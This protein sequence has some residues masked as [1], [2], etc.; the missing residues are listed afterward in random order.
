MVHKIDENTMR[1]RRWIP[2][3][4]HIIVSNYGSLQYS[5]QI[6]ET[7]TVSLEFS[8]KIL[9]FTPRTFVLAEMCPSPSP[10]LS[11]AYFGVLR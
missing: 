7:D 2:F 11:H 5:S 10:M 1:F 3:Y 8:G 9:T 6:L 4:L